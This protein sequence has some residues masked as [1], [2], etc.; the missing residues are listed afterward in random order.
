MTAWALQP[1]EVLSD[2]RLRLHE[3]DFTPLPVVRRFLDAA[4]YYASWEDEPE[5]VIDPAAGAGAWC[6]GMRELWP[7][8]EIDAIEIREEES[9]HLA[10]NTDWAHIGDALEWAKAYKGKSYNLAC[11][12]PP[13]TR[14]A[15]FA[16]AFLDIAF[17]VWLFAPVDIMLRA[18]EK[19]A[20][21]RANAHRVKHVLWLPEPVSFREG[22]AV[23]QRQYAL[24]MFTNG[25][26]SARYGWPVTLLEPLSGAE[27]R[28]KTR[29]GTEVG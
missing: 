11:T 12:N 5:R 17:D 10:R 9:E 21:L 14:F 8:A 29:P 26:T 24:W 20:W 3:A 15:E 28:W 13:F 27:R 25:V 4:P 23:D 7:D 2:K 18:K 6:V 22:G 16:E 19:A 1:Q